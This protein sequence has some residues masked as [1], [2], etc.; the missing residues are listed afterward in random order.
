MKLVRDTLAR[1][2]EQIDNDEC[3]ED[4]VASV[5]KKM[6]LESQGGYDEHSFVTYD[7]GMRIIGTRSRQKFLQTMRRNG[8][9]PRKIN[10]RTVGYLRSEVEAIAFRLRSEASDMNNPK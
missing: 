8:C 4:Y 1:W 10:N 2:I 3:S 5:V 9:K 7:E 6:D